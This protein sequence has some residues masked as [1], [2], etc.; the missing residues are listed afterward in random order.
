MRFIQGENWKIGVG[1]I[2]AL[3]PR[4]SS[5]VHVCLVRRIATNTD[6][7]LELGLQALSPQV[8]VV[9]LPGHGEIRRGI[10][11]H[12]LPGY[13]GRPGIIA[14]PGHLASGHKIKL[15]AYGETQLWQIGRR[16]EA[17]EGLEFFALVPL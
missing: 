12:R 1:N 15:S 9:D 10:Y 4:E 16:L 6:G 8:S 5:K 2:I 3:Q 11:L 17:S 13:G 7:R 14:R